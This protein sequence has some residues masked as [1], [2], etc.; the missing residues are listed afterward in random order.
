MNDDWLRTELEALEAMAPTDLPPVGHLAA[1]IRMPFMLAASA[2]V[3]AVLLGLSVLSGI[4]RPVATEPT[5]GPASPSLSAT[6]TAAPSSVAPSPEPTSAQPTPT[7]LQRFEVVLRNGDDDSIRYVEDMAQRDGR[8]FAAVVTLHANFV[9]AAGPASYSSEIWTYVSRT[10]TRIDT[11]DTFA[12]A[13]LGQLVVDGSGSLVASGYTDLDNANYR[14]DTWVS[15]D[16]ASWTPAPP[17][18]CP[19]PPQYRFADRH[20][21]TWGLGSQPRHPVRRR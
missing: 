12:H 16:G 13:K 5:Q 8:Y 4:L 18:Q 11:G 3:A 15:A 2:S 6:S 14:P 7:S 21:R 1:F 10:W 17:P 20:R 19:P 9:P